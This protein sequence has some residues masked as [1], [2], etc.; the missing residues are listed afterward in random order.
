MR[1]EL[2]GNERHPGHTVNS[3]VLARQPIL[4]R[5]ESV[6]GYALRYRPLTPSGQLEGPETAI[7]SVMVGALA[8]IGLE[9]LVGERPAYIEVTPQFLR[10]V[11]QLPLAPDRVV[12]EVAATRTRTRT[13]CRP[14]TMSSGLAFGSRSSGSFRTVPAKPYGDSPAP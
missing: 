2:V 1:D 14:C 5:R 12:L 10:Y 11:D 7:A 4:D 13:C 3:I 6:V 8:E 9:K